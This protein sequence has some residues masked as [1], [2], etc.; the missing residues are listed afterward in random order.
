MNCL[1]LG[2]IS[3]SWR[4]YFA[5]TSFIFA[6]PLVSGEDNLQS[7]PLSSPSL[8]LTAK[9]SGIPAFFFA[10]PLIPGEDNLQSP[11]LSSLHRSF[12]AK[13]SGI[14]TFFFASPLISGEDILLSPP[15]SSPSLLFPTKI[16][17]N[18]FPYLRQRSFIFATT[19]V[20]RHTP[21]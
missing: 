6:S 18:H 20:R 16:I 15:L 1:L 5:I 2:C 12:L 11:P 17:C 9:I 7:P 8:L 3:Y 10:S 21:H 13:I 14:P 4:R 19:F